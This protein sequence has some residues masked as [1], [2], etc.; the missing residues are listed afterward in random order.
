MK[1]FVL[2]AGFGTRLAPLTQTVPKP[3][4]PVGQVPLIGYA[5]KLLAQQGIT[6]V[7]VNLHHLGGVLRESLGDGSQYGVKITYSEEQPEILD[8][9]G[10]LKKCA[11]ALTETFV[12]VNS[13]T[14]LDIDLAEVLAAHR[15]SGALATMILRKDP[16]QGAYG[17]IEVDDENRIR[18]IVGHAAAGDTQQRTLRPF[19]YTGIHVVEPRFLDY[20]PEGPSSVIRA[21]YMKALDA[22]EKLSAFITEAYWVDAGTPKKYFNANAEM[23]RGRAPSRA[24]QSLP[25][26]RSPGIFVDPTARVA[27]DARLVAPVAIAAAC[28]VGAGATVGPDV[29]IAPG[30]RIAA[31]AVI[32]RSIVLDGVQIGAERVVEVIAGKAGRVGIHQ[33]AK[34]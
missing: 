13:D 26:A 3:M 21:G 33:D 1:G 22:G 9:G 20:L 28:E 4:F 29:V 24:V 2:A 31:G 27:A 12:A 15:A 10:G 25:P 14:I 16:E 8:T 18:R 34:G 17:Q 5:L 11:S 6:D 7:I 30:A 19:M 32:E 23:L